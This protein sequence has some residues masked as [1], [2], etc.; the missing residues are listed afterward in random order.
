MTMKHFIISLVL[1]SSSLYS[2]AEENTRYEVDVND[3]IEL[4]V[5]DGINVDYSCNADSI[6]K[7]YFETGSDLASQIL[8]VP[9]NNRLEIQ[10]AT[11]ENGSYENLPVIKVFSTYLT[12]VENSGD[13][14]V[15]ILSVAPGPKFKARVIG[16]GHIAVRDVQ[17]MQVDASIDTGN[18]SISVFGKCQR[19][20]LKTTGKGNIQAD[21]LIADIVKCSLWGT[22]SIG[23]TAKES[24]SILGAGSGT[25]YY[26]GNPSIKNRSI[27]VKT[28]KLEEDEAV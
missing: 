9:G 23:C 8:F 17:A 5:T 15:R 12:K 7:A 19:A 14:T 3:F 6:G 2:V 28:S 21:G 16:N 25:V 11:K 22:G 10:L 20:T 27:G 26:R 4:Y 24:L 18:G 1:I 13:S